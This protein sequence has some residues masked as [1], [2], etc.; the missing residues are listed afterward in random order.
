MSYKS[1][2]N[3]AVTACIGDCA[4]RD[5]KCDECLNR[6]KFVANRKKDTDNVDNT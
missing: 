3:F 1:R 2:Y 6:S 5:K 4:N